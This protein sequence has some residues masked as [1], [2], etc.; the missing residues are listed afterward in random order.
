ME[1]PIDSVVEDLGGDADGTGFVE[2]LMD[3]PCEQVQQLAFLL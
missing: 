2:R 1:Q 3:Q